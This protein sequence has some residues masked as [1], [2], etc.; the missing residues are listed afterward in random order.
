MTTLLIFKNVKVANKKVEDRI[1]SYKIKKVQTK[2]NVI[3]LAEDK[4]KGKNGK[5]K[6]VRHK[7]R[8]LTEIK[9]K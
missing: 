7:I 8:F 1:T 4:Q 5:R 3:N 6:R 9:S 2:G